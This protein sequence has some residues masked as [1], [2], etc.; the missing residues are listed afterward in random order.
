MAGVIRIDADE[1]KELLNAAVDVTCFPSANAYSFPT[2]NQHYVSRVRLL[3]LALAVEATGLLNEFGR[4]E[5]LSRLRAA[6]P[7]DYAAAKERGR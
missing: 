2:T 1:L 5:I 7:E 3:R 6:P 4:D